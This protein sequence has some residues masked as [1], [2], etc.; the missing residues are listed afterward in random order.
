MRKSSREKKRANQV[1]LIFSE[2]S[3]KLNLIHEKSTPYKYTRRAF[4]IT[5]MNFSLDTYY[6][7]PQHRNPLLVDQGS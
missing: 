6:Q 1:S 3:L 5:L 4:D 2:I 7:Y